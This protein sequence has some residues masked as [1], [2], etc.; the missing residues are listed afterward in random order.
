MPSTSY[1]LARKD[2]YLWRANRSTHTLEWEGPLCPGLHLGQVLTWPGHPNSRV[3]TYTH[4]VST[5]G[6]ST[7]ATSAVL[8]ADQW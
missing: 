2:R 7:R 6:M 5:G 1:I 8:A 3:E 4:T